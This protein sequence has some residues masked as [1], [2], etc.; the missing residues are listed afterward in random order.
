MSERFIWCGRELQGLS[1]MSFGRSF[2]P[3][4]RAVVL[5]FALQIPGRGKVAVGRVLPEPP[6][7]LFVFDLL[8]LDFGIPFLELCGQ[9][10]NFRSEG[11]DADLLFVQ[12]DEKLG[13]GTF[14]T[15]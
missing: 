10:F 3:S 14:G 5:W 13:D 6:L 11:S 4:R 9:G 1:G 15:F 2:F 12:S 8:F 7:Q